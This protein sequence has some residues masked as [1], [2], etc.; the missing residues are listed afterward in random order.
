V[1][2]LDWRT[3]AGLR[4]ATDYYKEPMLSDET[5]FN[6]EDSQDGPGGSQG[7]VGPAGAGADEV[8]PRPRSPLHWLIGAHWLGRWRTPLAIRVWRYGAGSVLAYVTSVV[9]LFICLN[10]VHWGAITSTVVAFLA[11]AVPNWILNRRWAWEKRGRDGFA[12][13]TTLYV[14]V[15]IVALIASSAADKATALATT[16]MSDTA[17]SLIVTVVYMFVTVVLTGLK[18]LAYDRIVFVDRG[19]RAAP[20]TRSR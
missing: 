3:T 11:G 16:H 15:S 4:T 17:R 10:W 18:Y 7:T 2:Y 14:T 20:A 12:K 1:G 13:E 9:V 8:T 5:I 6:D 19:A